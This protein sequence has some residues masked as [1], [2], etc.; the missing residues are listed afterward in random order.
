[1][2][3]ALMTAAA[4]ADVGA[5]S[6]TRMTAMSAS[7]VGTGLDAAAASGVESARSLEVAM[8]KVQQT[9]VKS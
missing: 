5:A 4:V 6:R 1:M 9:V 8:V 2:M 3:S 7:V